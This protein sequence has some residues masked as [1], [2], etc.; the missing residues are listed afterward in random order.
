MIFVFWF[1]FERQGSYRAETLTMRRS[2]LLT[3]IISQVNSNQNTKKFNA[4]TFQKMQKPKF[5]VHFF[6]KISKIFRKRPNA[7]E[8]AQTHPN[9]PKRIRTGPNRSKQVWTRPETPKNL[10][11]RGK[12]SRK[13]R[14]CSRNLRNYFRHQ[15][16]E[17][18]QI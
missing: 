4:K 5:S 16:V 7:S 3:E 6:S 1:S 9:A 15:L 17:N 12:T 14:K 8:R 13:R 11:K 10:R 18:F 2:Q